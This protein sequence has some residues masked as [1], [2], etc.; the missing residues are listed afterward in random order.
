[1]LF[2]FRGQKLCKLAGWLVLAYIAYGTLS[3]I[4]QRPVL[5]GIQFE[6]F[7]AFALLGTTFA[8]GYSRRIGLALAIVLGSALVGLE[9]L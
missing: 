8:L 5:T 7:A 9:A 1:M 4:K 6:H 3:P 2:E